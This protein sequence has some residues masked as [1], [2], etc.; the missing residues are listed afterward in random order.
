VTHRLQHVNSAVS[1]AT[2]RVVIYLL[3]YIPKPDLVASICQRLAP[4]LISLVS[5][6]HEIQF[7]AL[8]NI[9]LIL[10]KYPYVMKNEF[11]IFF[12][13]YNDPIYVKLCKLEVMIRLVN[14]ENCAMI[15]SELKEYASEADVEFVRRSVKYI[16]RCAIQIQSAA[17]ACIQA[18]L[19]LIETKV[20]YVLQEAVCVIKD[21]FRKYPNKYEAIITK[22][23]EQ[24]ESID[25][26]DAKAAYIWIVGHYSNRIS[27]PCSVLKIFVKDILMDTSVVQLALL[28]A[29]AKALLNNAP[30]GAELFAEVAQFL[31]DNVDN[32]D[33]RDRSIMYARLIRQNMQVAR[34]ILFS[35]QYL[36]SVSS[37]ALPQHVLEDLLGDLGKLSSILLR[38]SSAL[39]GSKHTEHKRTGTV[40]GSQYNQNQLE[41]IQSG[42]AVNDIAN[43]ESARN[44]NLL[45]FDAIETPKVESNQQQGAMNIFADPYIPD[46]NSGRMMQEFS[47]LP[48]F[49]PR[50]AVSSSGDIGEHS[51]PAF[52]TSTQFLSKNPRSNPFSDAI[53]ENDHKASNAYSSS[54]LT[55]FRE[56]YLDNSRATSPVQKTPIL[57]YTQSGPQKDLISASGRG[58]SSVADPL[59]YVQVKYNWHSFP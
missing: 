23:T 36:V 14:E 39:F 4:P 18:L 2:I 38:P 33:V 12:C 31:A 32:P 37:E 28:S 7:A 41:F 40:I 57:P 29:S 22:I 45:D 46:Q 30:G 26:P 55:Q 27:E 54:G 56:G 20:S 5:R 6:G 13:K 35:N 9:I 10:E 3:N 43:V 47:A 59:K 21:I 16:G 25:E 48:N 8:R 50:A 34:L 42:V 11:K 52:G 44:L 19:D 49:P 17:D 24:L 58:I 15:L 1:L 51:A 53:S